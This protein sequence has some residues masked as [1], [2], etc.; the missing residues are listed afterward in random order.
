MSYLALRNSTKSST[1]L[2][3]VL[4]SFTVCNHTFT[5]MKFRVRALEQRAVAGGAFQWLDKMANA[6]IRNI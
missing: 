2:Y 3:V 6:I 5:K 4:A 1:V